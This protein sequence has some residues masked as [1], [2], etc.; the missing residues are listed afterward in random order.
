MVMDPNIYVDEQGYHLIYSSYFCKQ[1][2]GDYYYSWNPANNT[3]CDLDAYVSAMGYAFSN[4]TGFSWQYR[5]TAV[6]A[7]GGEE[8]EQY[9]VE[10]GFLLRVN[11]T[12]QLYYSALG[13]VNGTLL[14]NRYQIGVAFLNI[15]TSVYDTLISDANVFQRLHPDPLIPYNLVTSCFTNNVQEPSVVFRNNTY[16]VYFL[17][18]EYSEPSQSADAAGQTIELL[19]LGRVVFDLNFSVISNITTA[20][21]A[22]TT[23]LVN[24]PE[25]RYA[26]TYTLVSASLGTGGQVH[27]GEFVQ[28]SSSSDGISWT[29]P[30]SA[31]TPPMGTNMF[32][33]WAVTSPTI[34]QNGEQLT[35]FYSAFYDDNSTYVD[36]DGTSFCNYV[37]RY[38]IPVPDP[39][40]CVYVALGRALTASVAGSDDDTT[41]D[42]LSDAE[43][44]GVVAGS[45]VGVALLGGVAYHL[46]TKK[47]LSGAEDR[48]ATSQV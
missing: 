36:T 22:N 16:E 9:K 34:H 3:A 33:N 35:L 24:I 26:D 10:T 14:D 7:P 42:G 23:W 46:M 13:Y 39:P 21:M 28:L 41:D 40:S 12:L 19:G 38:G 2:D 4:D 1:P 17:G 47:P 31:L 5:G 15:T 32:D 20:P 30:V 6:L 18:I 37:V 45:A 11:D 43:L 27:E 29:V 48:G 44:A 8:W 25:V